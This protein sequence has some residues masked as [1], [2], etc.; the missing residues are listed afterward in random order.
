MKITLF[1]KFVDGTQRRLECDGVDTTERRLIA[2]SS[3][4]EVRIV[5]PLLHIQYFEVRREKA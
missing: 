4:P 3:D 2:F 1:I 5:W